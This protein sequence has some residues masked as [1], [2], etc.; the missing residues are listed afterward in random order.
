MILRAEAWRVGLVPVVIVGMADNHQM[1]VGFPQTRHHIH[2]LGRNHLGAWGNSD[3]A[4]RTY[5]LD[6]IAIQQYDAVVDWLTAKPIDQP[7]SHQCGSLSR[8]A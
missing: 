2:S 4:S 1:G 5:S 3:L 8:F 6:V 7:T